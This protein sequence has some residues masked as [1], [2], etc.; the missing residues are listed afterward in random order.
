MKPSNKKNKVLFKLIVALLANANIPK[1]ITTIPKIEAFEVNSIGKIIVKPSRY[2]LLFV[3]IYFS[4]FSIA[5]GINA[6]AKISG[7]IESLS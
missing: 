2:L 3:L 6:N 1:R 7:F 5:N 4:K